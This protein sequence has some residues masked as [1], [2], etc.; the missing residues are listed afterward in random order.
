MPFKVGDVV[1]IYT[2]K[3]INPKPKMCVIIAQ[4]RE[5]KNIWLIAF[6]C[7]GATAPNHIKRFYLPIIKNDLT[8]F[9]DYDSFLN[10]W[11]PV[12]FTTKE[13]EDSIKKKSSNLCGKVSED[14]I[15]KMIQLCLDSPV[16][17]Y[18]D[19]LKY[20]DC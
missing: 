1:W 3:S 9:L 4:G 5:D 14:Q 10:C 8:P 11:D 13:I 7:T 20:F 15:S 17:E 6:I 19:Q 18:R 12:E 16:M 2:D